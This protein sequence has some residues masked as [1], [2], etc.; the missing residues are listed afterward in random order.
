[1]VV[2]TSGCCVRYVSYNFVALINSI[3]SGTLTDEIRMYIA[4]CI[5]ASSAQLK[6]RL[7]ICELSG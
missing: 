3:M 1:M 5:A 7:A 4:L 6:S 2:F